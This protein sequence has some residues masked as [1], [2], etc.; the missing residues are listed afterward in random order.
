M[1]LVIRRVLG[2]DPLRWGFW[3][4]ASNNP[5]TVV[6]TCEQIH[7]LFLYNWINK[8]FLFLFIFII[9][10]ASF[11][12]C[13]F[14]FPAVTS[15]LLSL[16]VTS[17]PGWFG[18][19]KGNRQ[20]LHSSGLLRARPGSSNQSLSKSLLSQDRCVP[21]DLVRS[22]RQIERQ[23]LLFEF[24]LR[25]KSGSVQMW[26]ER[27]WGMLSARWD[28]LYTNTKYIQSLLKESH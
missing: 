24:R 18:W 8:S 5:T 28:K 11:F 17:M 6:P 14:I 3:C 27:V 21:G 22:C 23:Q 25:R 19:A 26:W 4:P 10:F 13:F 2:S 20:G 15:F 12:V 16:H 9:S 1:E 7:R